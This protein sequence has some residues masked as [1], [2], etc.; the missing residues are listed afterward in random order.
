M[1]ISFLKKDLRLKSQTSHTF[2]GKIIPEYLRSLILLCEGSLFIVS[3]S[4]QLAVT[5]ERQLKI[6][7][8]EASSMTHLYE[9]EVLFDGF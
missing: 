6:S 1:V 9:P 7:L 2:L 5:S 3:Y 4:I 8:D